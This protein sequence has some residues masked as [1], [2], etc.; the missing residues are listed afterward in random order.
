M[1][2]KRIEMIVM[3]EEEGKEVK[4]KGGGWKLGVSE[5]HPVL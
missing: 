3:Q 1:K 4:G 5:K 2:Q